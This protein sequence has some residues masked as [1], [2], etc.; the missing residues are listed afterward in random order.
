MCVAQNMKARKGRVAPCI[1]DIGST[2]SVAVCGAYCRF[3]RRGEQKY[4][5]SLKG[6][7]NGAL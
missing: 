6:S 1:T 2:Q 5:W 3:G 7:D 4:L